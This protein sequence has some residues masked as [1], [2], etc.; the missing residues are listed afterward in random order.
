MQIVPYNREKAVDYAHTWAFRRNPSFSDFSALGGNCTNF[1]SQC[2]YAG[3]GIMNFRSV[4]GWYYRSMNDRSPSWTG[5]EYFN[6][7]LQRREENVGPFAEESNIF[8]VEMGDVIQL[9]FHGNQAFS[10]SLLV[11]EKRQGR[12]LSNILIATNSDDS[13][14]RPL[15]TYTAAEYR[16]LHVLGLR[17]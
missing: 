11:V 9:R 2:V 7:F 8:S 13:N 16:P 1:I 4:F 12:A 5:V 6:N 17:K 10:H 15:S 3:S 14:H